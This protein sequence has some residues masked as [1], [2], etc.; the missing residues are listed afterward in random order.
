MYISYSGYKTEEG[1]PYT[2]WHQYINKT[3]PPKPDNGINALFGIIIGG[4]FE[5]FYRDRIWQHKNYVDRLFSL[6]EPQFVAAT[7]QQRRPVMYD[8]SDPKAN[9]QSKAD[10]FKDVAE[11]I[12]VGLTL[13]KENRLLGLK[14]EP[15]MKLDA[16]FGTKNEHLI[17]GRADF[18]IERVSPENDL[19]ILDGKGSK[20]REKYVDGGAPK[21][22]GA[23]IEGTQ[24]KWYALLYRKHFGR[25]PD[26]LGYVFWRF[27]HPTGMEWIE[28]TKS[29]VDALEHQVVSTLDRLAKNVRRLELVSGQKKTYD[30]LRQELFPAQPSGGCRFCSY[31]ASCPEGKAYIAQA[32]SE[33]RRRTKTKLP[34]SGVDEEGLTLDAD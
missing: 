33:D 15:E 18:V 28:F 2:Y 32:E 23:P 3:P 5:V 8:W 34:L 13:I 12:P 11:A 19:I 29:S 9:Y 27:P 24:L 31:S 4:I 26:K 17:G 25:L 10:L 30:E 14:A 7:T 22:K 16:K 1:C 21:R 20:H 6:I